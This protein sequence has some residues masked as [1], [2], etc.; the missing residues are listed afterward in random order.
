MKKKV[1]T[2]FGSSLPAENE[3]QYSDAYKTG[4]LLAENNA[5]VC[6]G[7]YGG[8]MEGVSKGAVEFGGDAIGITLD[9]IKSKGNR[10]LTTEIKCR[11]L[12]ERI[13]K[14]IE[15]GDGYIVLQGG[16]GTL[17]ELAAIW[18]FM[19]KNLIMEKP[20]ACHSLMW[21]EIIPVIEKQISE[22]KRKT[23]LV[24]HFDTVEECVEFVLTN[25]NR[26]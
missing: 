18:E 15:T 2:V 6:S 24:K 8:I 22:E 9:Y 14:L 19:N 25:P 1:I 3:K 11:S 17:L 16:T 12:F 20:A 13:T 4:K 21:K 7:G 5:I 23:G 10:F 26:K